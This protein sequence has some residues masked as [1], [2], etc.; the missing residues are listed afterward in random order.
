MSVDEQTIEEVVKRVLSASNPVRII[1]FG[2]AATGGMTSDSDIDLLL[3]WSQPGDLRE[4]R[5]RIRDALRGMGYP[6]DIVVMSL[7]NFEESKTVFGG[8]AYPASR[9]GR[10]IY[11]AA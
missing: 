2:S 8:V 11:E 7:E 1:L 5:R 3:L 9:H 4:E 6:F 10:V